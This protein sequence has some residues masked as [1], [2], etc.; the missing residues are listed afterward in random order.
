ML[1]LGFGIFDD[2]RFEIDGLIDLR[3]IEYLRVRIPRLAWRMV[4]GDL[5][6]S[7]SIQV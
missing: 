7:T 6:Q 1:V 3:S 4:L 2:W 5:F